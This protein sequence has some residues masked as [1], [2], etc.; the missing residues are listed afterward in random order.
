MKTRI[1][2]TA[3]LLIL[4]EIGAGFRIARAA[5]L[6]FDGFA[7]VGNQVGSG[8]LNDDP[9]VTGMIKFN[10]TAQNGEQYGVLLQESEDG[11]NTRL[12]DGSAWLGVGNQN[13]KFEDFFDQQDNPSL[14][15]IRFNQ[16]PLPGNCFGAGDCH[17]ARWNK[18]PDGTGIEGYFSGW[19]KMDLGL[20]GYPTVWTH[21]KSPEN[22]NNYS[23]GGATENYYYVCTDSESK[24]HGFAWSAGADSA[25]LLDNPG[26]GWINFS[27]GKIFISGEPPANSFCATSLDASLSP[28]ATVYQEEGETKEFYFLAYSQNL[29]ID[30]GNPNNFQWLCGDS[31]QT[32]QKG[33]EIKCEYPT[34]GTFT[35]SLK[36][37]DTDSEE[38]ICEEKISVTV[39][40]KRECE[41]SV[42]PSDSSDFQTNATLDKG[43]SGEAQV[44]GHGIA[45]GNIEWS[46]EGGTQFNT[47]TNSESDFTDPAD[48]SSEYSDNG[49]EFWPNSGADTTV[50]A[51]VNINGEIVECDCS[52]VHSRERL[53]WR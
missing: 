2:F 26:L 53:E 29:D 45:D 47:N 34:A 22:P 6:N 39:I 44:T 4:F 12:L 27:E 9:P 52:T 3:L 21:F 31:A 50:C 46:L 36:I 51:N 42:T 1:L 37:F 38:W 28:S 33:K 25:S 7:W 16:G 49:L 15:W 40:E 23:C 43:E 19:A 8:N 20:S 5:V 10:G 18:K 13:D 14:G 30:E 17:F 41:V 32:P 24:V 48:D 35:P 11:G